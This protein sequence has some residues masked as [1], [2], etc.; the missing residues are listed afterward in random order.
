MTKSR[1]SRSAFGIRYFKKA[2]LRSK[3]KK[4]VPVGQWNW[5][6]FDPQR[7]NLVNTGDTNW[8][9]CIQT[10]YYPGKKQQKVILIFETGV[11]TSGFIKHFENMGL[12]YFCFDYDE[13]IERG[14]VNVALDNKG[15]KKSWLALGS[16][17]LNL[18]DV[19]AVLWGRPKMFHFSR[20]P[21]PELTN[22]YINFVRWKGLMRDLP[23]LINPRALWLPGPPLTGSFEWQNKLSELIIAK[24]IGLNTPE[25]ICT[26]NKK[27]VSAFCKKW[28]NK[29]IFREFSEAGAYY[30]VK[31]KFVSFRKDEKGHVINSPVVLQQYVNKLCEYRVVAVGDKVFPCRIDSQASNLTQMDWRYYDNARVRWEQARLPHEVEK[32]LVLFMKK[33]N[34]T[35]GSFDLIESPDNK[36]YFLEFNRPGATYWLLPFVGLDVP[37]EIAKYLKRI[38]K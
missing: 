2:P 33:I 13:F 1:I 21:E 26:N 9:D 12:T 4:R 38:L 31:N 18:N 27:V 5:Q 29:I 25:T 16:I 6:P 8:K 20:S 7:A 15:N 37:Y 14:F 24:Q 28:K 17:K 22:K 3:S 19:V 34:L 10:N 30:F 36:I 11:L 32:K 35:W 23:C